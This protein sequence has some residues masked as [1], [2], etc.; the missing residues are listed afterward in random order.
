MRSQVRLPASTLHV[1]P[2]ASCSHT[3]FCS[4]SSKLVPVQAGNP[5]ATH[6][7]LVSVDLQLRLRTIE[8][9]ISAAQWV[10]KDYGFFWIIIIIIIITIC[11]LCWRGRCVLVSSL[12]A[13]L[14][15]LLVVE[16]GF[17]PLDAC[18]FTYLK[19]LC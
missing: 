13:V 6:Y 19:A 17:Y 3:C 11:V 1:Q 7:S 8:T 9:E 2:W 12:L 4:Q 14:T 10:R 16:T 18:A 15:F 5:H